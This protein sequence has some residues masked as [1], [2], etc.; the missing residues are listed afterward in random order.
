[1]RAACAIA[2]GSRRAIQRCSNART[3]KI[4]LRGDMV[5]TALHIEADGSMWFERVPVAS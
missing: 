5:N 2:A 3:P 4:E 1:M